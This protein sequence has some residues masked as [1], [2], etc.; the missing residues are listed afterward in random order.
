MAAEAAAPPVPAEMDAPEVPVY[1]NLADVYGIQGAPPYPSETL[2]VRLQ[3]V[4]E[5]FV[6][7][8]AKRDE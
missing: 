6:A 5:S 2:Q 3:F 1:G 7:E 8:H 4:R